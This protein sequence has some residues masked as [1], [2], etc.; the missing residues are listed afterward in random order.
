MMNGGRNYKSS[1]FALLMKD[2][3]RAMEL[4]NAVNGSDY[5]NPEDVTINTIEGGVELSVRNDA[6]FILGDSLSIYEHQSTVCPNMPLRSLV[7]F[8]VLLYNIIDFDNIYG[9]RRVMLPTPRFA[10]FYNGNQS[11]P[12]VQE[13]KLSDSFEKKEEDLDLEVK[14][15]VYN[16]NKG[17][18]KELMSKCTWLG[19]YSFFVNKV[20]EIHA[21]DKYKEL[22]YDVEEAI[23]YCVEHGILA[24]FF[25]ENRKEVVEVAVLD[26]TFERQL[27]MERAANI[28]EGRAE[29][30]AEG[31]EAILTKQITKKLEKNKSIEQIAEELEEDISVISTIIDKIQ[32]KV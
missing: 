6:S 14:C 32:S 13:M 12:E 2:K 24:D 28:K 9:S 26:Y 29:G 1:V 22:K 16:I 25:K 4:Y 7:Y 5:D 3:R 27:E 21:L 10:V 19:D 8:M 20:R 17:K 30:R 18:N 15:V 31:E 23:D 11:L